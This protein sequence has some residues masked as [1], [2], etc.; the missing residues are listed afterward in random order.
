[1]NVWVYKGKVECVEE[2]EMLDI[3]MLAHLKKILFCS[4]TSGVGYKEVKPDQH[5]HQKHSKHRKNILTR[6]DRKPEYI[7]R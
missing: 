3:E 4:G 2:R 1:M 5:W 6:I 7:D